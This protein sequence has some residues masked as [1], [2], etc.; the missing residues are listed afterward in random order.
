[1]TASAAPPPLTVSVPPVLTA[2]DRHALLPLL[3]DRAA[4]ALAGPVALASAGVP[5]DPVTATSV[6]RTLREVADV[7]EP[8]LTRV[9][10]ALPPEPTP[11]VPRATHARVRPP[12]LRLG[13]DGRIKVEQTP[14]ALVDVCRSLPGARSIKRGG[15]HAWWSLPGSPMAA[16]AAIEALTPFGVIYSPG[17]RELADQV[18]RGAAARARFV[19]GGEIPDGDG[20]DVVN[21]PLWDHQRVALGYTEE[22]SALLLAIPMSGGKTST[23]IAAVNRRQAARVLIGCPNRVR[24][25]WPREVRER[26]QV[27]WHIEDGTRP[28]R[29]GKG[30]IDLSA[31]QR[32]ERCKFVLYDCDCDA[33]THAFVVNYE[34]LAAPG[35]RDWVPQHPL[36]A[37]IWDEIHRLKSPTGA[38]SKAAARFVSYSRFRL[39][40]SGTPAP[41]YWFDIFGVFRAL[42]PGIFGEVWTRFK[43]QWVITRQTR[44]GRQ[45]PDP[46]R[47]TDNAELARR[48]NMITYRPIVDLDLPAVTDTRREVELEPKAR[49]VY[50]QLAN[51][52]WADLTEF[53][54]R[55][56][57]VDLDEAA[58]AGEPVEPED[59][60]A[61]AEITANLILTRMLRLQQ[62][63]G[64]SLTTDPERDEEGEIVRPGTLTRV[65]TA[66]ADML[67][68]A[69]DEA[70]CTKAA[71][72]RGAGEPVAVFCRF[73]SDLDAVREVAQAAGLVYGEISGRRGDGLDADSRMAPT[74]QVCGVQ[75]QA[76]GTGVDLTRARFGVWYSLGYSV[77]DYDQARSRLVRI[78][79]HRPVVFIH[80]IAADTA[81]QAVYDAIDDRRSALG[82]VLREQGFDPL[83][84]GV[85]EVSP[86]AR[87]DSPH[88]VTVTAHAPLPWE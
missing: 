4:L 70:G 9:G 63:T 53:A 60:D 47:S 15:R 12:V 33:P 69:L 43:E 42:D 25:V 71:F 40:L 78:N 1:L 82:A 56:E 77:A 34:L 46:R 84:L 10:V 57:T 13:A 37:I 88:S 22:A 26:S 51:E 80:I 66:K 28:A 74:I 16:L 87:L 68:E 64:G 50:D 7:L 54:Q 79:Q 20:T 39:G 58:V 67:A 41:Q 31:A 29:R 59:A 76:G 24:G 14:F 3:P 61:P 21:M 52:L 86:S 81:D 23:A 48:F 2:I 38:T 36:D 30:R 8:V 65:S 6:A 62:L 32:L 85:R 72:A 35:W 19:D 83:R 73:R 49:K 27:G 55:G 75:I 44:E 5:I 18:G 17:V 11:V 45:F